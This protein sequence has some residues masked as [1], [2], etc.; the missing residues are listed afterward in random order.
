MKKI[1][2]KYLIFFLLILLIASML[3]SYSKFNTLNALKSGTGLIK[4][5][6][7]NKEFVEIKSVPKIFLSNPE[8]SMILLKEFMKEKGYEYISDERMSST[9]VFGKN[10]AKIYVEFSL[11]KYY[12]LWKFR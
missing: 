5:V 10:D 6:S 8:N 3:F 7:S 2:K 11:N 1:N 12:G 4:I 9:L